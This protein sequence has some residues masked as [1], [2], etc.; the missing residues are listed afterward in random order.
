MNVEEPFARVKKQLIHDIDDT[1]FLVDIKPT[2]A[3][4]KEDR[5][6]KI[7]AHNKKKGG[8]RKYGI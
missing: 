4:H 5:V 1:A 3:N 8:E 6:K 2:D 7:D